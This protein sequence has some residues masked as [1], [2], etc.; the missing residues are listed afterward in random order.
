M[1]NHSSTL[2]IVKGGL[3]DKDAT[4]Q[5]YLQENNDW[6]TTFIKLTGPM[7]VVSVILSAIITWI[8]SAFSIFGS[9]SGIISTFMQL[10]TAIIGIFIASFI[11]GYLAGLFQGENNFSKSF[12][13]LSLAAIPA[14][15][16]GIFSGLPYLGWLI[17]LG[18]GILSLVFLY[19]IIPLY[20]KVPEKKRVVHFAVSLITTLIAMLIISAVFG[21]SAYQ[22]GTANNSMNRI[23][24]NGVS[25]GLFGGMER[26]MD[27]IESAEND[28]FF[29]PA[30]GKI[31]EEQI[32]ILIL[33][34]KKIAD[35]R[36]SQ[37]DKLKDLD[38]TINDKEG[39]SFSDIGKLTSGFNSVMS[40]ANAEIEVVKT[41]G[42][43]WAEH[44]WV[45]EQLQIAIIQ[46]DINDTVKHNYELYNKYANQLS[47]L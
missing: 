31:T 38:T 18:L 20:L 19:K 26:Q 22:T 43:N 45:K 47:E 13:A 46:K 12:A 6:K 11:F 39:F 3:L 35:Y 5:S 28:K 10:I 21:V 27:M 8:F 9:Q 25:S 16:G 30:D 42:G 40:T 34:L 17:S 15:I 41:G 33:N 37:E 36:K 29:P 24:S 7:I 44:Q 1:I 23:G 4:W 32:T 2:E 14:Y